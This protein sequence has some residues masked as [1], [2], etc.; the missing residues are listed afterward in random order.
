M[1]ERV[2]IF[3][4]ET[5][6]P[7][8]TFAVDAMEIVKSDPKRFAYKLPADWSPKAAEV[9]TETAPIAPVPYVA[10]TTK[11]EAIAAMRADGDADPEGT[12]E[13]NYPKLFEEPP[14]PEPGVAG[15]AEVVAPD[16]NS[17]STGA[18]NTVP[19]DDDDTEKAVL[20]AEAEELGIDVDG[21]WGIAKLK[22]KIAT[23]KAAAASS[24]E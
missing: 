5:G 13:L 2:T 11:E 10:P 3:D 22:Q 18:S 20:V 9:V 23:A 14:A 21:R 19:A 4:L 6:A 1:P 8:D 17:I 12:A 24:P 15:P 7:T 16:P